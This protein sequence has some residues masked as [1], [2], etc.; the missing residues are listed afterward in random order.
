MLRKL[1]TDAAGTYIHGDWLPND[2]SRTETVTQYW[3]PNFAYNTTDTF[4]IVA[5]IHDTHLSKTKTK[6]IYQGA[7]KEI[8]VLPSPAKV[9][10]YERELANGIK[11]YPNPSEG[12]ATLAFDHPLT[13][14]N[15][16]RVYSSTGLL[17]C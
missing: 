10:G 13:E 15:A 2:V 11:I 7:Y 12:D 8:K 1:L 3:S 4:L 6:E 9:S 5:Y 17:V 16:I 14:D